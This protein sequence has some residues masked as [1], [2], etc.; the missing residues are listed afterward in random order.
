M[1]ARIAVCVCHNA[2]VGM[3]RNAKRRPLSPLFP[4]AALRPSLAAPLAAPA[5]AARAGRV[6]SVAVRAN[7][8]IQVR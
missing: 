7:K 3:S 8:Q 5:R 4:Q 6:G 2:G 1:F